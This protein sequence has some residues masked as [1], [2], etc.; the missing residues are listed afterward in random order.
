MDVSEWYAIILGAAI[1]LFISLC[2]ALFFIGT[3]RHY[4]TFYFFKHVVYRQLPYAQWTQGSTWFD[5]LVFGMFL[6]GNAFCLALHVKTISELVKRSGVI[7]AVNFIALSLG[8]RMNPIASLC[9][10]GLGV[11]S[12]VHRWFGRIT[13]ILCLTHVI[14]AL[15]HYKLD[16]QLRKDISGV[17]VSHVYL[18]KGQKT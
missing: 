1:G 6:F 4:G 3:V 5:L 12:Q 16:L 13:I 18:S 9:G 7:I 10:I 14:A 17:I 8:S 15:V 11:Y 2:F